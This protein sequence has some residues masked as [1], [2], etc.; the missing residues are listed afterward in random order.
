MQ[1]QNGKNNLRSISGK[2][3]AP[4]VLWHSFH[5]QRNTGLLPY[6]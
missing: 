6:Y 3:I 2:F 1:V 5:Q 4:S